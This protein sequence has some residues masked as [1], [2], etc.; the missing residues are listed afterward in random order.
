MISL[1]GVVWFL[2]CRE[3]EA[4]RFGRDKQERVAIL[5]ELHNHRTGVAF[6]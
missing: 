4:T 6:P 1:L 2:L 5:D 3:I